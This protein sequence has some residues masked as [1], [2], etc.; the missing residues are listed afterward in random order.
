MVE[1]IQWAG[2]IVFGD[3]GPSMQILHSKAKGVKFDRAPIINDKMTNRYKVLNDGRRTQDISE[4]KGAMFMLY[5]SVT[6]RG[7]RNRRAISNNYMGRVAGSGRVG[8]GE[9]T[10]V[11]GHVCNGTCIHIP[12]I[13]GRLLESGGVECAGEGGLIALRRSSLKPSC[14]RRPSRGGRLA[15]ARWSQRGLVRRWPSQ[16]LCCIG[17]RGL[18]SRWWAASRSGQCSEGSPGWSWSKNTTTQWARPHVNCADLRIVGSG[19]HAD[20]VPWRAW[21]SAALVGADAGAGVAAIVA[22]AAT[23]SA[24][25]PAIAGVAVPTAGRSVSAALV[26]GAKPGRVCQVDVVG[27]LGGTRK[28]DGGGAC[29][30]SGLGE[31]LEQELRAHVGE[32][33]ERTLHGD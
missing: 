17:R 7:N 15:W 28:Q 22:A 12:I 4:S 1:G 10:G 21:C 25:T 3:H 20:L 6:D 16:P 14:G 18:E 27:R 9:D 30:T 2:A 11:R 24:A 13:R 32:A 8:K 33:R 26:P 29:G 5:V 23:A 31:L 19:P